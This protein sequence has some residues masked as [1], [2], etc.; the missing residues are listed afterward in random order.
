MNSNANHSETFRLGNHPLAPQSGQT[1]EMQEQDTHQVL[2]EVYQLLE[3][4]AP[5]WY[6]ETHSQKI[7]AALDACA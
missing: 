5:V 6:Q 4:Y 3:E 7:R 2:L 1:E